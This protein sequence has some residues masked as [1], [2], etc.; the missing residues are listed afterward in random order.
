MLEKIDKIK[1]EVIEYGSL[2]KDKITL[3][4]FRLK[5]LSRK[6]LL[7]DLFE[8]F[9]LVDKSLKGAVGKALNELKILSQNVFEEKQ[10]EVEHYRFIY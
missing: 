7:N 1:A 2:I 10:K 9:K 8:D 6:G 3:E 4:E 5:F